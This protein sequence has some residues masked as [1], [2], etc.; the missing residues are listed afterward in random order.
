MGFIISVVAMSFITPATMQAIAH[1]L[2][3]P[4]LSDEA[5]RALAPDV[6]YRLREV[7]QVSAGGQWGWRR[8]A[9]R[10]GGS[11]VCCAVDSAAAAA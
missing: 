2:D 11:S 9:R 7:I 6:E 4:Q 8:P 1:S 10:G 5:A 3:I